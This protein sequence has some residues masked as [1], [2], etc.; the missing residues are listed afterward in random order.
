MICTREASR[1]HRM[2]AT[3]EFRGPGRGGGLKDL[4]NQ[5][6]EPLIDHTFNLEGM[7]KK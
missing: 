2:G 6:T 4:L 3:D 1:L 7:T 5:K